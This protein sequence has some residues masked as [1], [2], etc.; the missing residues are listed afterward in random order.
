MLFL[1]QTFVHYYTEQTAKSKKH[2]D[3]KGIARHLAKQQDLELKESF[4]VDGEIAF[5]RIYTDGELL[6]GKEGKSI[7]TLRKQV[8]K[9]LA[10][11]LS[12][13]S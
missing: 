4:G 7:K 12:A 10:K 11:S 9:I 8:Y 2:I 5:F 1:E 3:H 6:V 13:E